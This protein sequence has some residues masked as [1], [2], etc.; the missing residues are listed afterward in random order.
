MSNSPSCFEIPWTGKSF[1]Q[2]FEKRQSLKQ[3]TDEINRMFPLIPVRLRFR[4]LRFFHSKF[5]SSEISLM[6]VQEPLVRLFYP[7]FN[8]C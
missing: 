1:P 4:L 6:I 8:L 7:K 2:T 3:E 5:H